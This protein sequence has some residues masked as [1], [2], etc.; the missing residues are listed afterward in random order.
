[1]EPVDTSTETPFTRLGGQDGV[2]AAVD[3]LYDRIWADP[4]LGPFF[5]RTDRVAQLY[6][7]G[8]DPG[9]GIPVGEPGDPADF[10]A[11]AAFLCSVH[12]GFITGIG[13]PLDGGTSHGM[14]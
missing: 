12:A 7:E 5:H 1:M 13:L 10:G 9:A 3:E 4:E 11:T 2:A 14:P 6:G 8:Q